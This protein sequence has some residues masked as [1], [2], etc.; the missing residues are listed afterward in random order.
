[1]LYWSSNNIVQNNVLSLELQSK[2]P[3]A[4]VAPN[5][6]RP[7]NRRHPLNHPPC[8]KAGR[9]SNLAAV[10]FP[11]DIGRGTKCA[12]PEA[13]AIN[14]GYGHIAHVRLAGTALDMRS[15]WGDGTGYSDFTTGYAAGTGK[16]RF[17]RTY[18]V[19]WADVE[20]G[21]SY[22]LSIDA[23][24]FKYPMPAA[25]RVYID[26]DHDGRFH[27][28][29]ELVLS[30]QSK[31]GVHE[32]IQVPASAAAGSTRMRVVMACGRTPGPHD[33]DLFWGE[34]EDYTI[35]VLP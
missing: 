1:M 21:R 28:S 29:R 8:A 10:G 15:D 19:Q 20:R 23:D 24:D 2:I 9:P 31:R 14:T 25:F 26:W 11:S 3:P 7:G 5:I 22:R 4:S 13:K 34:V 30:E 27:P 32:K 35:N 16:A 33:L 18:F 17:H 6:I 12:Y